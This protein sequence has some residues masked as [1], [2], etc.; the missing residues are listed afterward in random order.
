MNPVTR[1]DV[2][3][4]LA[5]VLV[6]AG[7]SVGAGATT[8][9]ASETAA[10]SS[11]PASSASPPDGLISIGAGLSGPAGLIADVYASG[12]SHVSAFAFDAGG[13]LWLATADYTDSGQDGVYLVAESGADP[14]QIVS[15]LHTPLGLVW[16][17]DSLYVSS[18][19]GV[20]AYGD[21]DGSVFAS[22]RTIV[23][24]PS[25]VGE[26]NGIAVAP[27]G[28]MVVGISAPCNACEPAS[29]YSAAIVSFLP[30]GSDLRVYASD[31]RAA[32]GLAFY[33]GTSV[34]FVTMN[35]RD[36]LADATPG[37][38]LAV[39]SEGQGW[40]F[41]DCYGQQ[42][43]HCNGTPTPVAVLDQHAA[44]SGVAIVTGQLGSAIGSSA[45]V[46]EWAKGAVQRVGLASEGSTDSTTVSPFLR[47]LANP[48]PLVVGPDGA[49]YVGDWGTGLVYRISV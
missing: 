35:Q 46:A 7:C 42:S 3:G 38:W 30:D 21:L 25:G 5:V 20:V 18:A 8:G 32:V 39:V 2:A 14:V 37:D 49:V 17:Q 27:D 15:G 48:V 9:A 28:R 6:A 24:F 16:Y 13:R 1:R 26:V 40:G 29:E 19:A 4:L 22:V 44:V 31:I 34:L 47:G 33:P 41:P 12:V 23:S 45:L 36:D 43:G 11:N 10:L